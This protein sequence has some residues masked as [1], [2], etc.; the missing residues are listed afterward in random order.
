MKDLIIPSI[1]VSTFLVIAY[2]RIPTSVDVTKVRG[3]VSVLCLY[4]FRLLTYQLSI[5]VSAEWFQ[6][7]IRFIIPSVLYLLLG[8]KCSIGQAVYFTMLTWIGFSAASNVFSIPQVD[9]IFYSYSN[10]A[11]HVLGF[12]LL[13]LMTNVIPIHKIYDI[14][15]ERIGMVVI[16]V[17]CEF[18]IDYTKSSLRTDVDSGSKSTF[19]VY[20]LIMQ[21]FIISTIV[22]FERFLIANEESRLKEVL[23]VANQ[24]RVE[25]AQA[26]QNA[27]ENI[28]RMHHDMKNHLIAIRNMIRLNDNAN[29]YING[30]LESFVNYESLYHTGNS[31]LDGLLSEKGA[32]AASNKIEFEV[33]INYA[34]CYY[35]QDSDTCVIFG[36]AL[37]NAIEACKLA[38]VKKFVKVQGRV[39]SNN[40]IIRISNSYSGQ[41]RFHGDRLMTTKSDSSLHG[42]GISSIK[43]AVEKY[44]G[45]IV[46]DYDIPQ[47]F[48]LSVF[49]PVQ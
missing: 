46:I 39:I 33:D 40:Y 36:N 31:L 38:N 43:K 22:L 37:D 45:F 19:L 29:D 10:V 12:L 13:M 44:N 7:S 3:I 24:Y 23:E 16:V 34:N 9:S 47:V 18:Y 25:A 1:A 42:I 21:L 41:L 28:S 17:A 14:T 2:Y 32:L 15:L 11:Y 5:F 27:N 20:L 26:K 35:V 48:T 4:A 8:K 30:L 6:P 49:L